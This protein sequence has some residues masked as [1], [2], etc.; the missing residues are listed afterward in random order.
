MPEI[1]I[2]I[3]RKSPCYILWSDRRLGKA[4]GLNFVSEYDAAEV[5]ISSD[6]VINAIKLAL[7]CIIFFVLIFYK[8]ADPF[9]ASRLFLLLFL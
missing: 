8:V 3:Q 1:G 5:S 4:L 6:M 7:R 9:V 2:N